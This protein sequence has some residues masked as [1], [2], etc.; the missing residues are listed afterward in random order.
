[1]RLKRVESQARDNFINKPEVMPISRTPWR[2]LITTPYISFV[3][4]VKY[5]VATLCGVKWQ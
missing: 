2:G 4:L 5:I 3:L 1:M